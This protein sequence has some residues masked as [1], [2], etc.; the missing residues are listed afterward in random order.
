MTL[1]SPSPDIVATFEAHALETLTVNPLAATATRF[2]KVDPMPL[3]VVPSAFESL[4]VRERE[5]KDYRRTFTIIPLPFSI[6]PS[7]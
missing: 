6:S 7:S 4:S 1:D 3:L 2:H 5:K